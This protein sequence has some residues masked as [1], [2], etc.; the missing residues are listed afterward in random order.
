MVKP[1][2]VVFLVGAG[3]GDPGL[4]TLRGRALLETCDAVVYDY[5][6]DEGLLAY[7]PAGADRVYVG[8]TGAHRGAS[9]RQSRIDEI[10]VHRA[11]LGQRVV[12]LKGGDPFVFGRGGEEAAALASAGLRFEVVPGVSSAIAAPAYAGIP[13]THRDFNTSVAF[14]T[15]HEDPSRASGRTDW[16]AL[17][18]V[19]ARGGTLVIL[20]GVKQLER[21]MAFLMAHNVPEATPVALVRWGTR[22]SQETIVGSICDIA[23]KVRK[24]GLKPP[25]VTIV[26]D[27]VKLRE[28]IGWFE[29]RP[30]I[31]KRVLITRSSAKALELAHT[32]RELGAIPRCLPTIET[33]NVDSNS[34]R[35]DEALKIMGSDGGYDGLLLTSANA[36]LALF[37]RLDAMNLDSR[38]FAGVEI[39][40]VGT[41]TA[42]ALESRGLSADLVP[43][44]HRSDALAEALISRGAEGRRF[45]LPQSALGRGLLAGALR[46]AGA[47]VD[48]IAVYQTVIPEAVDLEMIKE[49]EAGAL[50]V[51]IFASP[52]AVRNLAEVMGREAFVSGLTE[53]TIA[54]IGPVTAKAVEGFGLTADIVPS[55]STMA[56]LVQALLEWVRAD[57]A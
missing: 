39:A 27:V 9:E 5:L 45:F 23:E 48:V 47:S 7:A 43:E 2:G 35:I 18:N 16:Q 40:C 31:G 55:T 53:T 8:K 15:G 56:H 17:A 34:T 20:M 1:K 10:L 57:G 28:Q 51:A 38:A 12:R 22:P 25:A 29:H 49:V 21:N 50:E 41:A 24:A 11:K 52:S 37:E 19:A 54:C 32:L 44:Q 42:A 6:V 3:P 30:L 4:L 13:I 26:G 46:A 36:V 33:V 14:V